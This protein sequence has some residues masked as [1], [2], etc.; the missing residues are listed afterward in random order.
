[1]WLHCIVALILVEWRCL[2]LIRFAISEKCELWI[3]VSHIGMVL[4]KGRTHGKMECWGPIAPFLQTQTTL[5]SFKPRIKLEPSHT[6]HQLHCTE[7]LEDMEDSMSMRDL[8]SRFLSQTL[9]EISLC[10]LATGSR[11]TIR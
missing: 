1:M 10:L 5:I 7:L 2:F 4:N 3:F 9:M 6:S 11:P 8:G